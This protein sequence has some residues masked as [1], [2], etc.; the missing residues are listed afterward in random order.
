[1]VIKQFVSLAI[2]TPI[3]TMENVCLNA[4]LVISQKKLQITTA[5]CHIA[6]LALST[7]YLV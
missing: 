1:V 3:F 2:K 5:M 7:V 4:Q 6:T